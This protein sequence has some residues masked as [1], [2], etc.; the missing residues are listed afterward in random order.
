[1]TVSGAIFSIDETYRYA[2]WRRW[3]E[4]PY[5]L[6]VGLNPSTADA[7]QDDPTVRRCIRFARDW[8]YAAMFMANLFA[9]R[10]T[11]PRAL[12]DA[13]DPVGP[14]NDA[15][16][17]TL[18]RGAGLTIAAWGVHGKL[19]DRE[20]KVLVTD[21]LGDYRV[22]GLTAAGHPRHPLYMRADCRPLEPRARDAA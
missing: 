17:R 5:A 11:D 8:G 6:F 19:N 22:L 15:W 7:T 20:Y 18:A 14:E 12:M 10:S 21:A 9:Y 4:G 2:L 16:L 13:E 3:A 1:M